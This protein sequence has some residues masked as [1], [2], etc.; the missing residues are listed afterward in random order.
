MGGGRKTPPAVLRVGAR[1]VGAALNPHW[2]SCLTAAERV[3][4]LAMCHTASDVPTA[5]NRQ[6][7]GVF[8]AGHEVL[9][10]IALGRLPERGTPAY[11]SAKR[12]V[13]RRVA[14]L[15]EVGALEKIGGGQGRG[16]R[17]YYRV[18]PGLSLVSSDPIP[19]DNLLADDAV[20]E[21]KAGQ[22]DHPSE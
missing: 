16:R 10:I 6:T 22:I 15:C 20:P 11:H 21:L 9:M 5:R 1:L 8:W 14:R 7:V 13:A 18:R 17:S 3:L 2:A 19:V 12:L 4:L